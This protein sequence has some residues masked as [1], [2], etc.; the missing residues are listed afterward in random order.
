M[1]RVYRFFFHNGLQWRVETF[2][3]CAGVFSFIL[4]VLYQTRLFSL[5]LDSDWDTVLP[6]YGY[7]ADFI[8]TQ[9]VL[10]L[11]FPYAGLGYPILADPLSAML[12]PFFMIPLVIFGLDKGLMFVFIILPI[13]AGLS[14]QT[15]LKKIAVFGWIRLWASLL[16]AISGA[17]TARFSAGHTL[18]FLSYPI[19]PILAAGAIDRSP[20]IRWV[21]ISSGVLALMFYSGDVYGVWFGLLWIFA[22]RA[23]WRQSFVQVVIVVGFFVVFSFPK[24]FPTVRDTW[25]NM[26]RLFTPVPGEGSVHAALLPFFYMIP[27]RETFYDRPFFQ[28]I[29]GFHF[30]WY[31]YYAFISPLSFVFLLFIRKIWNQQVVRLL[32]FILIGCSLYLAMRYAYSPFYWLYR[33]LPAFEIMRVPQRVAL[34]ATAPL[35]A[36]LALGAKG[37]WNEGKKTLILCLC[38]GSLLWTYEESRQTFLVAFEKPRILERKLVEELRRQDSSEFTVITHVCCLQRWLVESRIQIL[39]FYVPWRGMGLPPESEMIFLLHPKYVIEKLDID[40]SAQAYYPLFD[41]PIARVWK[42]L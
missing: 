15:F 39:N 25:P 11:V 4:P 6:I 22:V 13:L 9:H 23:F 2:L 31:E 20:S 24:L 10:P 36:L 33:W 5:R 3:L 1:N 32:V 27:L 7:I 26:Q 42:A 37:A 12:N 8:R 40:I 18:F 17:L 14:M 34:Y 29:L 19:V 38:V 41:T 28:R 35:I 30:N 21:V 16:Y